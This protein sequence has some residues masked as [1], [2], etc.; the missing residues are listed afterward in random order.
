MAAPTVFSLVAA[1]LANPSMNEVSMQMTASGFFPNPLLGFQSISIN[2][3][4]PA[5]KKSNQTSANDIA[6]KVGLNRKSVMLCISKYIDGGVENA[7]FDAPV[8]AEMLKSPMTRMPG[9]SISPTKSQLIL[10]ML[11]KRGP[12]QN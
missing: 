1:T 5:A 10:V 8:V 4:T 12:M 9:S 7:L 11:L 3:R 2:T 6:G